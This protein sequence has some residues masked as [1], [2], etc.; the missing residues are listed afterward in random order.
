M[1]SA[2][3]PKAADDAQHRLFTFLMLTT[4]RLVINAR[5]AR[6][7]LLERLVQASLATSSVRPV[8]PLGDAEDGA[9]CLALPTGASS[10]GGGTDLVMLLRDTFAHELRQGD[11]P[12][13]REML[14][15][16]LPG[17]MGAA[18]DAA[19]ASWEVATLEAPSDGTSRPSGVAAWSGS[20]RRRQGL[21]R[22]AAAIGAQG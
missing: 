16:W 7:D 8:R 19:V 22:A 10:G 20:S 5:R 9:D 6:L 12:S 11:A 4:S 17:P 14:E 21:P 1:P 13:S 3:A 18:V 2:L 15:R